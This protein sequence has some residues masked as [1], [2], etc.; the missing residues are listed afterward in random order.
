MSVIENELNMTFVQ[1]LR[2]VSFIKD[3]SFAKI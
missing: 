1:E 3:T 2:Q